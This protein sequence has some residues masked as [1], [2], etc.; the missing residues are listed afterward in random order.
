MTW[1]LGM[2]VFASWMIRLFDCKMA[3][4]QLELFYVLLMHWPSNCTI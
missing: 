4:E 3:L 2:F 1:L